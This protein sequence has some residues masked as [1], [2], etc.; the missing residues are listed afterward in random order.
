MNTSRTRASIWK[1]W[2]AAPRL[3]TSTMPNANVLTQPGVSPCWPPSGCSQAYTPGVER[4]TW[5]REIASGFAT[6]SARPALSTT[7]SFACWLR[8]RT[9]SDTAGASPPHSIS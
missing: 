7:S 1:H 9:G 2:S 5:L 3:F 8:R 6:V 4:V